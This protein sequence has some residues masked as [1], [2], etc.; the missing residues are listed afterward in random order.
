MILPR[1]LYLGNWGLGREILSALH[2][3]EQAEVLLVVTR[4]DQT[5]SDP[6]FNSVYDFALEH[7]LP[8]QN[9]LTIDLDGL[10]RIIGEL[11]PDLMFMHSFMHRLKRDIF[12]APRLGT[13]NVH[14]S[15]LP[16]H[17]GS[18]PTDWVLRDGDQVTGLTAH[19]VDEG[20]DTGPIIAQE[21]VSVEEGDVRTSIIEKL[22][23][24]A[25]PLVE[26]TLE[27]LADPGF[28]PEIQDEFPAGYTSWPRKVKQ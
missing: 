10:R 24:V 4:Y 14:P 13:V 17:R 26:K 21:A 23:G 9:E 8:V 27:R 15:L 20:L 25:G 22:K 18:S 2:F 6:W 16:R 28:V 5:T 1:I 19:F 3:S 7:G 12:D 11:R